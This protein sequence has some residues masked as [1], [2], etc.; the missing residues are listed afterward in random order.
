[1][2]N[3]GDGAGHSVELGVASLPVGTTSVV[4]AKNKA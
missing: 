1:V 2:V 3:N 4:A